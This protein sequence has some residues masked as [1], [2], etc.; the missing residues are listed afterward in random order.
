[1]NPNLHSLLKNPSSISNDPFWANDI[2]ILFNFNRLTEFFPTK[3]M[4][5]NEILNSIV[6]MS[7][8]ISVTLLIYTCNSNYIYL[9]LLSLLF[10]YLIW[11]HSTLE[12]T[13]ELL[14]QPKDTIVKKKTIV[15]PTV[16]NP[17]MNVNHNEYGKSSNRESLNKLNHYVNP[18]LNN[19]ISKKYEYNLYRDS[20]D[21]FHRNA[22]ERQFYTM[23]V[24]TIPN[25][26]DK[27][28]NW[29]YKAPPT[30]KEGNGERC[31]AFNYDSLKDS[32][33]RNGI[34]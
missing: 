16:D 4:T 32:K 9:F 23:P 25:E 10:T 7:L 1:M 20:D 30:C 21:I 5:I 15:E 11:N 19:L 3:D 22:N 6:R 31:V 29:L 13:E 28:A 34:F 27:F 17:F 24:T 12:T 18:K 8:Y 33:I 2:K 26:Q 14:L